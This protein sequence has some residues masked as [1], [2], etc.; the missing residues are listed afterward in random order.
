MKLAIIQMS[1]LHISSEDDFIVKNTRMLARTA[2]QILNECDK[3]VFVITGDIVNKG[4]VA[5]YTW[6]KTMLENFK[7]EI[8]KESK[9]SNWDYVMVPGNHDLDFS[10]DVPFREMVVKQTLDQGVITRKEHID[11]VLK[12][13]EAFWKFYSEMTNLE[14][15]NRISYEKTICLNQQSSLVFHCYNT[16][17]LSTRDEQP[18]S[19][20]IPK[21]YF[22]NYN[23]SQKDHTDIVISV[24]H[25]KTGWLTTRGN[26][27]N[28]HQFCEHIQKQSHII[29]CGHEH[30][31]E[32]KRVSDLDNRDSVLYLESDSMQQGE[33][34]SFNI[35][36]FDDEDLTNVSLY[37]ISIEEKSKKCFLKDEKN[38]IISHREHSYAFSD[39]YYDQ[40]H[41]LDAPIKHPRKSPLLL[42]DVF[43]YPDLEPLNGNVDDDKVFTYIDSKQIFDCNDSNKVI[44]L[45]GESQ[46]GKTALLKMLISQRYC[47]SVYPILLHGKD[48]ST[49]KIKPL[50]AKA[51]NEQYDTSL[52]SYQ[53][54]CSMERQKRILFIDNLDKSPLNN[55]GKREIISSFLNTFDKVVI[56]TSESIDVSGIISTEMNVITYSIHSLGYVKRN[57]LIEKWI[58]LGSDIYSSDNNKVAEAVKTAYDQIGNILGKQFLPSNPIFLLTLLQNIDTGIDTF[59][60][61]PTSYA[62]LYQSLLFASL[63]RAGVNQSNLD[64]YSMFL[65]ELAYRMFE[66]KVSSFSEIEI[67]ESVDYND[68]YAEYSNVRNVV[69]QKD[70]ILNKLKDAAIIKEQEDKVY[71]F[72]YKYLFFY[73]TALKLSRIINTKEGQRVIKELCNALHKENNANILLFLAYLDKSDILLNE[74]KFTSW[75]PF[76]KLEPITLNAD[77]KL[78]SRLSDLVASLKQDVLQEGV[79]YKDERYKRLAAHDKE[80]MAIRKASAKDTLPENSEFEQNQDLIDFRNSLFVTQ[81]MGQ[82]VKNQRETLRK[83]EL[84][85]LLVDAY[86]TTFRSLSFITQII[87]DDRK[88]FIDEITKNP[89]LIKG[90]D[91]KKI[92]DRLNR[93]LQM[94]LM[95][96][97]LFSFAR[98]SLSVGTN[99]TDMAVIYDK[100]AE[101]IGT[102]A[103]SFISFTIKTYYGT[104]RVSELKAMVKTYKNNPV[105]L[106]LINARVRNYVYNHDLPHNKLAEL[107]AITGM[108]LLDAPFTA[109][110]KR[111]IGKSNNVK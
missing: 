81:I 6:A 97:C 108:K 66:K 3:A 83:T 106:R 23:D 13:Q 35:I 54:Y 59:D 75:L 87:E 28:R 64:G 20:L 17:L 18:Q 34:Q 85:D 80:D 26:S 88:S 84:I 57:V 9:I 96:F 12:P 100:V 16:A 40:L 24:F 49:I 47:R 86:N 45:E 41:S 33:E 110:A 69:A 90:T 101:K 39:S 60:V 52:N 68:F 36:V 37:T 67:G 4:N 51:Y 7:I 8:E 29:M 19:L 46:C 43:V 99:G 11:E 56:T 5:N 104:M 105:I 22:L 78:Y 79:N 89:N 42:D 74:I 111:N 93:L 38:L 53:D 63:I 25:H 27:N 77:D 109:I 15:S 44:I 30:Q 92:Q 71:Q 98:L 94:V 32:H 58:M 55:I 31:H 2:T 82:I 14:Y 61:S 72:S 48:V 21:D 65:S 50:L 1:D 76:E 70:V 91:E 107:G 10:M 73:L 62:A 103:A 102:P 95:K